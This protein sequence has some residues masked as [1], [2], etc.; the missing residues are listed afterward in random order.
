MWNEE[1]FVCADV[2]RFEDPGT[3]GSARHKKREKKSKKPE[4]ELTEVLVDET[5]PIE[6]ESDLD[7]NLTMPLNPSETGSK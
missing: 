4:T 3:P 2:I 5:M 1:V 6:G 7:E